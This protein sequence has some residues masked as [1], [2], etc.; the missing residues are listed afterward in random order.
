[1]EIF[2]FEMTQMEYWHWWIL[3]GVFLVLEI[4]TMSFFFLWLGVSGVLTG[5]VLLVFPGM[6]WPAQFMIWALLALAG[7]VGWRVYKKRNPDQAHAQEPFLNRRGEQYVGRIFTLEEPVI[8]GFGR[9]SVDDS[10]WRIESAV[11]NMPAGSKVRVLALKGT[12]L[13]VEAAE[14]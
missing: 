10:L 5:A 13:R 11:Q 14:E 1:M 2:G 3:A 6:G 9:V 7:A 4:S 12:V 8:D